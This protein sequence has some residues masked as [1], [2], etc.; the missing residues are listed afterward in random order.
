MGQWYIFSA[1]SLQEHMNGFTLVP[2]CAYSIGMVC[3]CK[4]EKPYWFNYMYTTYLLEATFLWIVSMTM[5]FVPWHLVLVVCGLILNPLRA[6]LYSIYDYDCCCGLLYCVASNNNHKI[7][8]TCTEICKR[9]PNVWENNIF[10]FSDIF[11][12]LA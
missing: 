9:N 8:I 10:H 11:A 3:K 12:M 7:Y 4:N 5:Q 6:F 1:A 2:T